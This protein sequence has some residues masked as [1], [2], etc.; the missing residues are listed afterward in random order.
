MTTHTFKQDG[1]FHSESKT[2]RGVRDNARRRG[3]QSILIQP[4]PF[5]RSTR[6][7]THVT[8]R[9]IDGFYSLTNF[10]DVGI[11]RNFFNKRWPGKV[12]DLT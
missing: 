12:R 7:K 6:Y 1:R 11:C 5:G 4:M 8:I 9:Y 10:A 2:L 3:V